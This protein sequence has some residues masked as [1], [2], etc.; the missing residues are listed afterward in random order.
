MREVDRT[1][2]LRAHLQ[3]A[4]SA[5]IMLIIAAND[6]RRHHFSDQFKHDTLFISVESADSFFQDAATGLENFGETGFTFL[7]QN[8]AD[9][10]TVMGR[11]SDALKKA[12]FFQPGNAP[13]K[14]A[15]AQAFAAEFQS[16]NWVPIRPVQLNN[17]RN[18]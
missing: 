14:N 7:C 10:T 16:N 13:P 4:E 1:F 17:R 2:L 8:D 18:C 9:F 11:A 3:I 5:D 6:N 12:L 15:P